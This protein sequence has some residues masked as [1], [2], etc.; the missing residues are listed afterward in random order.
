MRSPA[1]VL[2]IVALAVFTAETTVSWLLLYVPGLSEINNAI[3]D[4]T[5]SAILVAPALYFLL[6]R[7]MTMHV[8]AHEH[9]KAILLRNKEE[10]FKK[11]IHSSLDGF[12]LVDK[13]GR[14]QEVNEAY[15][16]LLG[17]SRE[18]LLA[19][20]MRDVLD[21]AMS[22]EGWLQQLHSVERNRFETRLQCRDDYWVDVEISINHSEDQGGSMY[23]FVHDISRRKKVNEEL[24]LSAQ[25]LNSTSDTVFLVD[26]QGNIVYLNEAAYKSR[27]YDRETLL[28]MNLADLHGAADFPQRLAQ[29]VQ[30]ESAFFESVHRCQDGSLMP[31]EVNARVTHSQGQTLILS[32][33]RDITERRRTEAL[34]REREARL[35]E[36]F[37]NLSSGVVVFRVCQGQFTIVEFNRAAE[38]LEELGREQVLGKDAL[39]IFPEMQRSGV[40]NAL[41]RVFDLGASEHLP[42]VSYQRGWHN[43]WREYY[44]Y[45]LANED[46]VAIYDDITQE[47]QAEAQMYHLAHYDALTN[48]PNRTLFT[49][50]LHHALALARRNHGRLALMFID[51]DKFKAVNDTLGHDAGDLLLREVAKR[52]QHCL[53][54]SDSL[55]RM[56]GDEFLVLLSHIEVAQDAIFAAEKLLYAL[57]Q[58]FDLMGNPAKISGS[59]GVA[60]YPEHGLTEKELVKHADMAMYQA[61]GAG[62]DTILLYDAEFMGE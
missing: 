7:P 47:K 30:E 44:I 50:H 27:G 46:L 40:L 56:G 17:Y 5:L 6:F 28:G 23:G 35:K 10:R 19:L 36:M 39:S 60:L 59:I 24:R 61:K 34:L 1:F 20:N 15:C 42:A 25:L 58:P 26:L 4:G 45:R 21:P 62:R 51:L 13:E 52:M 33:V 8:R 37:E 11:I 31:V 3:M 41:Q 12:W 53:R 29:I 9:M 38:R 54:E 43:G 14:F 55:A 22:L 57:N 2:L 32:V 16:L 18:Q 48:L 49:E